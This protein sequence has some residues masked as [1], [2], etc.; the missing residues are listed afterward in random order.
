[1]D[2]R[3]RL[4]PRGWW[5]CWQQSG[6]PLCDVVAGQ[7]ADFA[8]TGETTGSIAPEEQDFHLLNSR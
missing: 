5:A 6:K 2:P 4:I 7:N 1:L 3:L 8:E